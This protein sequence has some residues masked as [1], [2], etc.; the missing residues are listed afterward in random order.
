M[1]VKEL[2]TRLSA[3]DGGLQVIIRCHWEGQAA[4]DAPP[5]PTFD[6]QHVVAEMDEDTGEE[7]VVVEADQVD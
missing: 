4:G 5:D 7:R 2:T 3:H 1:T 6:A